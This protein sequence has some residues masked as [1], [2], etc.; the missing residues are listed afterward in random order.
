MF[1]QFRNTINAKARELMALG[2]LYKV[3]CER[4]ELWEKYLNSFDDPDERQYH[5]CNCCK[6]FIRQF[7]NVVSI[8]DNQIASIWDVDIDAIPDQYK[9]AVKSLREHIHTKQI[10]TSFFTKER[11][12]GKEFNHELLETGSVKTWNHFYIDIDAAYVSPN[13][14]REVSDVNGAK[15]VFQ[16]ALEEISVNALD[17]V[18]EL[19]E[20]NTLY[21]GKEFESAVRGFKKNLLQYRALDTDAEKSVFCWK[22]A[23]TLN[24]AITHFKNSV[25]GTLVYDLS[26]GT[27]TEDAVRIYES[28]VAPYNY[29]RPKA[30]VTQPM[31]EK[32]RQTISELG[33]LPSLNRR[34]AT[35]DDI[36]VFDT[37]YVHKRGFTPTD[38][39]DELGEDVVVNPAKYANASEITIEEFIERIPKITD[40]QILV[41]N[42]LQ[43]N[44]VSLIT[45]EGPSMFKWDNPMCWAYTGGVTDSI[46]EKVKKAGGRV[47][48]ELRVSLSWYNLDDLDIHVQE[49]NGNRIYYG[50]KRSY[51]SGMLDVD[52][53][54]SSPKRGAV[55]NIIW[56]EKSR[57]VEGKYSVSVHNYT[58]RETID[59]GYTVEIEA[60]GQ[61][62]QFDKQANPDGR[63]TDEACTFTWT[64]KNGLVING[65]V[66][67]EIIGKEKWG[68]KTNRF[69]PVEMLTLSPNHLNGISVGNKHYLFLIKGM[70]ND[71]EPRGFFN[72]YLKPEL[73][74]NHK[75][76]FE[77]LGGKVKV[78]SSKEQASGIGFSETVPNEVI[79]Q[80]YEDGKKRISKIKIA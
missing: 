9:E 17:V 29:K 80:W 30:I 59:Q 63:R 27:D 43:S 6:S 21:R 14:G 23:S 35:F 79:A 73:V 68:I 24:H 77:V 54:V 4:D 19:I 38:I 58:K 8:Q 32:A 22:S 74:T 75:R 70:Q 31:I 42:Q 1:K 48:G 34:F 20:D 26:T 28:K 61:V 78:E 5:N 37:L 65:N 10:E 40:L 76:V 64:K 55:E 18:I 71:E 56:T 60:D 52:M 41:T 7:G 62:Y 53:N 15:Q 72:E 46:K 69:Y 13:Y 44:F 25:I 11:S 57:M 51:S 33:Y 36:E 49:P 12:Y 2:R 16:R 50:S 47:E 45:G 39:F 67:S 3:P 66:K